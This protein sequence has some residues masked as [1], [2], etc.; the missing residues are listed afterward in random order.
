[1]TNFLSKDFAILEICKLVIKIIKNKKKKFY[2]LFFRNGSKSSILA[3]IPSYLT[4]SKI[5][6]WCRFQMSNFKMLSHNLQKMK[7]QRR[8]KRTFLKVWFI[9]SENNNWIMELK[10][11]KRHMRKKRRKNCSSIT[12]RQ[13]I[14]RCRNLIGKFPSLKKSNLRFKANTAIWTNSYTFSLRTR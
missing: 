11:W 9:G 5:P 3:K 10:K 13:L 14:M 2:G 8:L 1:M 7:N 6:T 12:I 4:K